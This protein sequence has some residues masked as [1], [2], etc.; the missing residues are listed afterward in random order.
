M[1]IGGIVITVHPDDRQDTEIILARFSEV[2]VYGGDEKGNIIALISGDGAGSIEEVIKAIEGF[3]PVL[4]VQLA[5][6]N[7]DDAP[8]DLTRDG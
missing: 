2:T 1:S 7:A 8:N 4:K 3:D 5:Y 6:L